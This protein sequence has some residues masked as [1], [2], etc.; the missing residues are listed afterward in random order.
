VAP[1]AR[2]LSQS[3]DIARQAKFRPNSVGCAVFRAP[4]FPAPIPAHDTPFSRYFRALSRNL[5]LEAI[6]WKIIRFSG[7]GMGKCLQKSDPRPNKGSES[8]YF[9]ENR[10]LI[11]IS[12]KCSKIPLKWCIMG[13]DRLRGGLQRVGRERVRALI[14]RWIA[15]F[16]DIF[17]YQVLK[18]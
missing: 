10:L 4:G 15:F 3:G 13:G 9:P 7:H 6:F 11:K 14:R 18:I 1:R 2:A 8:D 17:P 12:R 16:G 5:N